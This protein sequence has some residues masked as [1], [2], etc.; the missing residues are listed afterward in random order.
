MRKVFEAETGEQTIL[1]YIRNFEISG[2]QGKATVTRRT[3]VERI[4]RRDY[5]SVENRFI[6]NNET[7]RF[8]SNTVS[9]CHSRPER[10]GDS[11]VL[12]YTLHR[13]GKNGFVCYLHFVLINETIMRTCF[14]TFI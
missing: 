1:R 7:A 14:Y 10:F 3:N 8:Y 4:V 6:S 2:N 11:T 13:R 12:L 5:N 9:I